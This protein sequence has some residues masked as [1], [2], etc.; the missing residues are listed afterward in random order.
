MEWEQR[1]QEALARALSLEVEALVD[2]DVPVTGMAARFRPA[3]TIRIAVPDQVF[4]ITAHLHVRGPEPVS[5]RGV[6]LKAPPGWT[7]D[8]DGPSH[9]KVTVPLTATPSE[10]PW[11]R[12]SIREPRY[13]GATSLEPPL[14]A[15]FEY[16]YQ[17]A[18]GLLRA[19]PQV[20]FLDSI[21]LQHREPLAVGP[22]VSV[23]FPS[24]A[25]LFPASRAT[26]PVAV[27]V[28]NCSSRAAAGEVRLELPPGWSAEPRAISFRFAREG[29]ELLAEF[30]VR[31]G[32]Q[33]GEATLSAVGETAGGAYRRS[34]E[35]ITYPGLESL[36][37][38]HRAEHRVR[39][40]DIRVAPGLRA[41]YVMGTG[42]EVPA[43]LRQLGVP[44]DLLDPKALASADL[45]RYNVILLGIRA[46]AA[47]E[48]VR[49][50]NARLLDYVYRGGTLIVQY[51]TQEYDQNYGPYPYRMTARAEEVSEEDSPVTILAPDH[52]LFQSP[53]RIT[54]AD[55]AGWFEQRGS[56]FW[57][58]WD[59]RY[60]PLIETHDTG[61][62][63]QRGA[64]LVAR[65]GQGYYVY[66][67]LAWY[68]QLP[69]VVPGAFRLFA[70]LISLGAKLPGKG[71]AGLRYDP[72]GPHLGAGS[73]AGECSNP[74]Q[75][76]PGPRHTGTMAGFLAG[77]GVPA[78]PLPRPR[79]LSPPAPPQ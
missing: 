13:T 76:R 29:D 38:G 79:L 19:V 72:A 53:N 12:S 6:R 51:N 18:R 37:L 21:G 48:D 5:L 62:A 22:A 77:A 69:L 70:N 4:G 63:P 1:F 73:V 55:F 34:F 68:R 11:S 15:E 78:T 16:D 65:H 27:A 45:S 67:A 31:T 35:R 47:R 57:T 26:Y 44:T 75:G 7:L 14:V 49:A 23:R 61:Q 64:W 74:A 52:P 50:H 46:Y 56:K 42:D 30:T 10:A 17:G 41:A 66:C 39:R 8:Q 43:A 28:R 9:F 40:M 60:L 33:E 32:Q 2:P 58:T 3:T 36:Y 24:D 25:G 71:I 59:Q 20:S 54:A